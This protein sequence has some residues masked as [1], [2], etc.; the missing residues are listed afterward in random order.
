VHVDRQPVDVDVGG[1]WVTRSWTCPGVPTPMVSP[2]EISA[3]P[4]SSSS[5]VTR[6][7]SSTGTSPW[8]GQPQTIET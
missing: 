7:T 4:S 1:S 3:Q 8:S 5:T 6:R 2:S